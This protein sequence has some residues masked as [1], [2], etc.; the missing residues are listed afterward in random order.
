MFS[1]LDK[2]S[3]AQRDI[4]NNQRLKHARNYNY[5]VSPKPQKRYDRNNGMFYSYNPQLDPTQSQKEFFTGSID[6]GTVEE[7]T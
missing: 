6:Q 7:T 2:F 1:K 5:M 3:R 4:T